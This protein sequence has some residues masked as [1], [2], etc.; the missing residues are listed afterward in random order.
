VLLVSILTACGRADAGTTPTLFQLKLKQGE[1][2]RTVMTM[3]Q[4]IEQTLLG[5][6]EKTTSVTQMTLSYT[7]SQ[8][9]ADGTIHM[10]CTYEQISLAQ[11]NANEAV[12]YDSANPDAN[13]NAE[14]I[15]P[16]Y[17]KIIGQTISV[18]FAPTGEAKSVEGFDAIIDSMMESMPEGPMREQ[19]RQSMSDM[20]EQSI[21]GNS[22]NL[23]YFPGQAIKVGDSWPQKTS[24]STTIFNIELD[25]TYTLKERKDG[26]AT[27]E[28]VS[29]GTFLPG[30][31][32]E[33]MGMQ[34]NF[35][36]QGGQTGTLAVDEATG[37]TTRSEIQQ[38]YAGTIEI[39][40]PGSSEP[41]MTMPMTMTTLVKTEPKP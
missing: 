29:A 38:N 25:T 7:V 39:G 22:G 14:Q 23:A 27:I 5:E 11:G 18:Q 36:M 4:T 3:D 24:M 19:F 26:I 37:W 28:T 31:S 30:E 35:N 10:E 33:I 32:S 15:A 12:K 1:T 41:S 9:A 6:T 21:T 17:D 16:I 8:V 34:M 13:Q 2:Y 20:F 40:A